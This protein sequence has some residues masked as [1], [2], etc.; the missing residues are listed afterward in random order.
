M[1]AQDRG[2][3]LLLLPALV[4]LAVFLLARAGFISD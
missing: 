2:Q 1:Q 4:L 3:V